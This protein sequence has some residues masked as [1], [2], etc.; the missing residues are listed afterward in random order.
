MVGSILTDIAANQKINQ[1]LRS[2][3]K[4]TAK[5]GDYVLLALPLT[6]KALVFVG[7]CG[8]DIVC[9]APLGLAFNP[10]SQKVVIDYIYP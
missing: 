5:G 8:E 6:F 1:V 4:P 3:W 2:T 9:N 10:P 7:F